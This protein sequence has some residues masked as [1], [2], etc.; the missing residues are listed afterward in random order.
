MGP[1]ASQIT[2]LIIVYSTV[3]SGADQRKH[4]SSASLSFVRGIPRWPVNSPHKWPV[5]RKKVSIWWRHH[6]M[7]QQSIPKIGRI[8]WQNNTHCTISYSR[9]CFLHKN[10]RTP[11]LFPIWLSIVSSTEWRW[12]EQLRKFTRVFWNSCSLRNENCQAGQT[13]RCCDTYQIPQ[14][15]LDVIFGECSCAFYLFWWRVVRKLIS[16]AVVYV[17]TAHTPNWYDTYCRSNKPR[18]TAV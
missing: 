6:E 10:S 16:E 9:K 1:V 7:L 2:S 13:Y 4:Q 15:K 18:T 5:T 11:L 14:L 8:N 3:Y 12:R 17:Y